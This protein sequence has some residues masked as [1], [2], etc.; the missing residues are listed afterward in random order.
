MRARMHRLAG[1]GFISCFTGLCFSQP[2]PLTSAEVLATAPPSDWRKLH[3][4][5]T[6]YMELPA[7]RV[8]IE[9]SPG[10]APEG[11]ANIRAMVKARYFDGLSIVRS[12]DNYVVQWGGAAPGRSRGAAKATVPAEFTRLI[13]PSSVFTALPDPDTY[14][15]HAGFIDGFPAARDTAGGDEWL[16]HCYGMVGIGRDDA[17]DSGDGSELYV[18]TGQAPRHLDRNITLVGRVVAG[19][20]LLSAMPRGTGALG[21]YTKPEQRTTIREV[22]LAADV[23]AAQRSPLEVMRTDSASFGRWIE[24]RR[25]R[26]EPW[27]HSP[28]GR[29]DV[30]NIP[31]PVRSVRR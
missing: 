11:V 7:G 13:S 22:R 2:L 12:Q 9:F 15:A 6:L 4:E 19:M 20:E 3:P 24:S 29:I 21:F 28:A 25:N 8:V 23:P 5:R 1:L 16:V 27:F 14:A 31:V 30:C 17:P 10:F 18:V 26:Q